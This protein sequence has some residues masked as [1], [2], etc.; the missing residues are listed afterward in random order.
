[1][2]SILTDPPVAEPV[3]LAEAK[4]YLRLSGTEED[5]LVTALIAAARQHVE[6][7]TG[8]ALMAQGWSHFLDCWPE[9]GTIALPVAPLIA[10]EAVRVF[11]EDD[12][13]ATIDEA[14][15]FA[16]DAGRPPRFVWRA[17]RTPPKPGRA[18]NGIEIA[19]TA[20]FA[21]GV[22]EPLLMAIL[23]I[24]AHRFE[25][26]GDGAAPLGVDHLLLTYRDAVL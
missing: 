5:A 20:G 26:R 11:G 2:K 13:P 19:V 4:A 16:D 6:R 15:Y 10:I 22:P 18:A 7:A 14:H 24:V 23:R 21:G 12:E 25:N 9:R 8:L 17:G 1:M 3:T